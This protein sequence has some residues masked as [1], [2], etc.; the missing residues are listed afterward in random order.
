MFGFE[1]VKFQPSDYVDS[2]R[3]AKQVSQ[4]PEDGVIFSDGVESD[5]LT[6]HSGLEATIGPADRQ[7]HLVI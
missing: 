4:M 2:R 6:F 7:G 1:F 5:F 3:T